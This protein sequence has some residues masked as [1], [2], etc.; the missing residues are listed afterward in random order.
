MA[1]VLFL[2][3]VMANKHHRYV[4]GYYTIRTTPLFH[5]IWRFV[6][7]RESWRLDAR[8]VIGYLAVSKV[9]V[10]LTNTF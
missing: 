6:S 2:L 4:H 5:G 3:P 9:V 10:G 1:F 8:L 7:R